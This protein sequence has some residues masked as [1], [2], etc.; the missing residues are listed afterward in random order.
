MLSLIDYLSKFVAFR[1]CTSATAIFRTLTP[2]VA[3]E[4]YLNIIYH[5]VDSDVLGTA[6]SRAQI[7]E[8]LKA[9][10]RLQNGAV[11]FNG[12][13]SVYGLVRAGTLI[14]RSD[15]YSNPPWD[16]FDYNPTKRW[17]AWV[18]I[19]GYPE[20]PGDTFLEVGS[21]VIELANK[22]NVAISRWPSLEDWLSREL[23]RMSQLFDEFGRPLE[24]EEVI[25]SPGARL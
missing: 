16:L 7:P 2:W 11:L 18:K 1:D 21:G 5:P 6:E 12:R 23:T 8:P 13:L 15:P 4:A 19:G 22:K 10:Y 25:N 14:N 24:S 3:P 9:F 17:P 20:L